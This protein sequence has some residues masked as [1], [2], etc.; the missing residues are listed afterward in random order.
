MAPSVEV[1]NTSSYNNL[2]D[3]CKENGIYFTTDERNGSTAIANSFKQ[4]LENIGTIEPLVDELR[5]VC[6]LYDFD[7]SIPGNGYRSYV[8]VV[9][10][11]IDHCIKICNQMATNRDSFFFRKSFY[12]KYIPSITFIHTSSQLI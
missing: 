6:H 7:P 8:C 11:F 12:T 5:N 3:L 10:L 1:D 2:R 9:D 4:L